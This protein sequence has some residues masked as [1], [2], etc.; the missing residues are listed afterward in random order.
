[1][2]NEKKE[3]D[4]GAVLTA[5]GFGFPIYVA[6]APKWFRKELVEY[7]GKWVAFFIAIGAVYLIWGRIKDKRKK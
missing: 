1:M 2:E 3:F 6:L 5:F 7:T 4:W